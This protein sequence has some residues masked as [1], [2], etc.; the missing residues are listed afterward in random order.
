MYAL[1]MVFLFVGLLSLLM[2]VVSLVT[3]KGAL[4]FKHKTK[5][6]GVIMWFII[7][8]CCLMMIGYL[9]NLQFP[10]EEAVRMPGPLPD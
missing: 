9:N 2:I 1:S 5:V 6:K 8:F 4:L 10:P 7:G 3:P